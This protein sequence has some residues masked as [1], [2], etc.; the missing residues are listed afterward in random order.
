MEVLREDTEIARWCEDTD[1]ENEV[2]RAAPIRDVPFTVGRGV[3]AAIDL[4]SP[5][6]S[7]NVLR[8][9]SGSLSRYI[10]M[11]IKIAIVQS[12]HVQAVPNLCFS[13]VG[14][15]ILETGL[16]R[17]LVCDSEISE[18]PF[19]GEGIRLGGRN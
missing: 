16:E 9:G 19:P 17:T 2:F 12:L 14:G 11:S 13:E 7:A 1:D 5:A 6:L 18:R 10:L 15:A 3:G 4:G 8:F